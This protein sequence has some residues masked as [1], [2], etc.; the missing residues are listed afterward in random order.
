M[1]SDDVIALAGDE[2]LGQAPVLAGQI[3]E[4]IF[5]LIQILPDTGRQVAPAKRREALLQHGHDLRAALYRHE[6]GVGRVLEDSP[7]ESFG[8]HAGSESHRESIL[9]ALRQ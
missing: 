4:T 8:E 9:F 5:E 3:A 7:L 6:Q 2:A 1:V